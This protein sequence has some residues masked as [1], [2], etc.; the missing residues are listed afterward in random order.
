MGQN[1]IHNISEDAFYALRNVDTLNLSEN[2]L[3]HVPNLALVMKNLANLDLS[4]NPLKTLN[5]HSFAGMYALKSVRLDRMYQ[6][7]SLDLHTF[8]ENMQL[9]HLSLAN[10]Q[11]LKPLPWGL[12]N[13]NS[14]LEK[15]DFSNNSWQ[16]L[17]P[18]Q[19][20]LGS[21]RNLDLSGIPFYCNC[22]LTWLWELYQQPENSAKLSPAH[23]ASLSNSAEENIDLK[24]VKVDDLA[25]A[26]WTFVL[27]VASISLL[28]TV[29]TLVLLAL[30]AYKCKQKHHDASPC[31]HI[32]DDTMI[33]TRPTQIHEELTYQ[34]AFLP[35]NEAY[36]QVQNEPFYEVPKFHESSTG[37]SS[38][39][40]SSGYVGS[41]LWEND[42]LGMN[43]VQHFATTQRSSGS[44]STNSSSISKPVFFSPARNGSH[45]T[46]LS[47]ANNSP[48]YHNQMYKYVVPP[49]QQHHLI[50]GTNIRSPKGN[51]RSNVYV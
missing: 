20:P 47:S 10:N 41:E 24:L 7:I 22:S 45:L 25:C 3:P 46:L 26:N 23:C 39:Y 9:S 1:Q 8:V 19:I 40:S 13:S 21:I 32:K 35:Q 11:N 44:S 50:A 42:F 15:V 43:S 16:T 30:I 36:Q 5:R 6:L 28:V 31:L 12:F 18:Y 27:L 34:K 49:S 37:S 17:S 48:K 29:F 38:K 51:P 14:A 4:A 2:L 33:Y